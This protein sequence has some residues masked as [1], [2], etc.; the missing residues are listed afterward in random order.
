MLCY[1]NGLNRLL[2]FN[3]C[4]TEQTGAAGKLYI[5]VWFEQ[6]SR[7]SDVSDRYNNVA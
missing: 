5:C 6:I 1:V 7:Y 3:A 2:C 4:V